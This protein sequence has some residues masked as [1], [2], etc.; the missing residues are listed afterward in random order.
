MSQSSA[1]G[2]GARILFLTPQLPSPTRQGAAIRNWN[3]MVQLA[4][5]HELDLLTFSEPGEEGPTRN[6]Q[7]QGTVPWQRIARIPTPR[8]ANARRLRTL[9][10]SRQPDMADRLWAPA[11]LRQLAELLSSERYDII[12]AEG[13]ELARYLLLVA[14]YRLPDYDPLLVFDEHNAEWVLQRRAARTDLRNPRRWPVG[15]YSAIQQGRLRRFEAQTMQTADLTLCVSTTD[16][17]AL[18]PL[19]PSRPLI[20][21]PNGVDL[22]YYST[23]GI[24]RERPRFDVIFSGTLDYRPNIDAAIWLV[25]EIWPILKRD[26]DPQR[27]R[28]LRLAL[29]GRNPPQE[30]TRLVLNPGVT[31]TG[32]VADDRPY[33]AGATVYVLPM[34]YGG[35]SRL[36][37]LNALAMG[38][39]VVSTAAG[40]EGMEVRHDEHLLIADGPVEFAAAVGRLL[41]DPA[42]RTRLGMAGQAFM[43]DHY[44]WA[45]IAA[46]VV[47]GYDAA[48]AIR[49]ATP[50][51]Q[52]IE[53]PE[54][55]PDSEPAEEV[56]T[57]PA[58]ESKPR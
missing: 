29:I 56:A 17:A 22:A 21:A 32:S 39:A 36:K 53:L 27:P 7:V 45:G 50:L 30:I 24:P 41:G 58:A 48:F 5:T 49:E 26:L 38:C 40:A 55:Q 3:L 34:R 11:M 6:K 16:A 52:A 20:V 15:A 43:R 25:E 1:A 33:F 14:R 35:G 19:A 51:A 46:R 44:D 10:T 4:K 2:R 18:Q 9:L 54:Y 42:L 31:V 47:A 12:Q 13:I 57:Q 37:L 28:P 23:E 8:R